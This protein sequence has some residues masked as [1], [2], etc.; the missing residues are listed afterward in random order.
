MLPFKFRLLKLQ[1]LSIKQKI[2]LTS[3]RVENIVAVILRVE[4]CRPSL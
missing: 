3:A 4:I 1:H 2:T